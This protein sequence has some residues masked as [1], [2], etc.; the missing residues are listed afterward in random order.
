MITSSYIFNTISWFTD[1]FVIRKVV[2][3]HLQ[4]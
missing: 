2:Q 1:R 3:L 4:I